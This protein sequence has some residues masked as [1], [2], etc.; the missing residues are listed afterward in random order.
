MID[1]NQW[2]DNDFIFTQ[3]PPSI[4]DSTSTKNA[5]RTLVLIHILF[6]CKFVICW[7]LELPQLLDLNHQE[8][9]II[10]SQFVIILRYLT[11]RQ[12]GEQWQGNMRNTLWTWAL[13]HRPSPWPS[14]TWSWGTG[15]GWWPSCTRTVRPSSGSSLSSNSPQTRMSRLLLSNLTFLTNRKICK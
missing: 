11:L 7:A 15:G 9:L 13:T 12:D 4:I 10:F 2:H 1:H 14:E 3:S 8:L 6:F 5:I